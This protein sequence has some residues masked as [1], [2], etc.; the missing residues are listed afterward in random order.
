ML[1]L[2]L[3]SRS[4]ARIH[5]VNLKKQ[6][7]LPITF[8]NPEDYSLIDSGDVVSTVGLNELLRGDSSSKLQVKVVKHKTGEEKMIDVAH[9]LSPDQ[10]VWLRAGSALNAIRAAKE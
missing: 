1:T 8:V 9:T 3:Y 6:G 7:V 10:L 4:F 5:E 2:F